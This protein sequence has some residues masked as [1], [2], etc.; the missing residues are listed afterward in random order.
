MR[1][2]CIGFP[3]CFVVIDKKKA[4]KVKRNQCAMSFS[5]IRF[6]EGIEKWSKTSFMRKKVTSLRN[7]FRSTTRNLF[8]LLAFFFVCFFFSFLSSHCFLTVVQIQIL[9]QSKCM[10]DRRFHFFC[11][12]LFHVSRLLVHRHYNWCNCRKNFRLDRVMKRKSV[13]SVGRIF[14]RAEL[15]YIFRPMNITG[16]DLSRNLWFSVKSTDA[17]STPLQN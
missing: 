13:F 15:R 2:S 7:H 5:L 17:R 10:T 16:I 9:T 1:L 11:T 3:F 8:R 4:E 14:V 12:H 6:I